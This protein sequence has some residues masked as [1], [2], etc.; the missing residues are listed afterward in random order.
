MQDRARQAQA[1]AAETAHDSTHELVVAGL[2]KLKESVK[3]SS[4][5]I[6]LLTSASDAAGQYAK[7]L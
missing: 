5:V 4:H 7:R 2:N 6:D 3:E 1:L